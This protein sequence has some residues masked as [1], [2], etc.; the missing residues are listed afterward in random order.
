MKYFCFGFMIL[1]LTAFSPV[2]AQEKTD[3]A[4]SKDH[5][6]ISRLKGSVIE[7]YQETKWGTYKLPLDDKG[8]ISF[9]E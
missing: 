4:D 9:T 6:A 8:K 3:V 2:F 7:F 5:P 1:T